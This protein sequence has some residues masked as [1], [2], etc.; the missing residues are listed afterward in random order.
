M[1]GTQSKYSIP[2]P[3]MVN[4]P[5]DDEIQQFCGTCDHMNDP[6]NVHCKDIA[7]GAA[8]AEGLPGFV[9]QVR[10]VYRQWCNCADVDGVRGKMRPEG[11]TP[12]PL[13]DGTKGERSDSFHQNEM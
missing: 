2:P 4:L 3:S 13:H 8:E 1:L 11:F 6:Y 5:T 10:Y 12:D 9:S 7:T